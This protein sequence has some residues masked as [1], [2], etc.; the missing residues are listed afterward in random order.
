MNNQLLFVSLFSIA[1]MRCDYPTT[2]LNPDIYVLV[3]NFLNIKLVKGLFITLIAIFSL[4]VITAISTIFPNSRAITP[5]HDK[6]IVAQEIRVDNTYLAENSP[7]SNRVYSQKSNKTKSSP[8]PQVISSEL[9]AHEKLVIKASIIPPFD[10]FSETSSI[11]RNTLIIIGLLLLSM[12]ILTISLVKTIQARKQSQ[13]SEK[14]FKA[15][16]EASPAAIMIFQN[17]KLRFANSS[18]E[19]LTGF[20]REELLTMEIWQLIH[21]ES[22]RDLNKDKT[23]LEG[24]GFNFRA[25]L[26]VITKSN[27]KKWID[28]STRSIEFD[29]QASVLATAIDVTDKKNYEQQL[30]EAEERYALILLASN[31]GISDYSILSDQLYLSI[32][33]KNML[34]FSEDEFENTIVNWVSLVYADDRDY[35]QKLLEQLNKGEHSNHTTEYRMICK[36]GGYQWVSASFSV[37]FDSTNKP[38]RVL[39]THSNIT[40]RKKTEEKLKESE[41]RYKSLFY[42]NSAVMLITAPESGKIQD[43]NQAAVDYYGFEREE[44]LGMNFSD[45]NLDNQQKEPE[46]EQDTAN[47]GKKSFSH[48]RHKLADG[49]V[50]DVEIYSSKIQVKAGIMVYSIIFDITERKK[51]EIELQKAKE[52]AEEA[53][54]EKTFFISNVSHEIRTPLNAIIGLTEL[55]MEDENLSDSHLEN[56]RSIKY[57]SDH[58]L[59]VINDVL[60]FSKLEAG[61]VQLEKTEFDVHNLVKESA[62]T[63]NFKAKEKG[64]T[65]NIS[66]QPS[67]PKVLLGDPSRLRQ[68]ILNL[69][70]NAIKFTHEGHINIDVLLL[71]EYENNLQLRFSVSDTG[72]GIPETKVNSIFESFTQA[73]TNTSRKFGGTGLGLSICKKLVE[74]QN[75]QMGVKSVEG[76]GSTFWFDLT[77]EVSLKTFLPDANKGYSS[78]KNLRGFKIL[79]VE[80][81]KMNQFVMAQIMKKWLAKIDIVDNGMMAIQKL[82]QQKYNLVLMDLHMPELNGYEATKIIRNPVSNVLDHDVPI[83]ALTADV[84]LETRERVKNAGMNDFLSKPSDKNEM[85]EKIIQA[86][87][88]NKSRFIENKEQ[89]SNETVAQTEKNFN[90]DKTKYRIKK[91]LADIFD[92]DLEGTLGLIT[93]FLKDIPKTIVGVNEAFYDNDYELLNSL[94]HRIKP[95]YSY[96][97]F[98]DVSEKIDQ[99]Q[100]LTQSKSHTKELEKL[101]MELDDDSRSIVK[102]LREIKTEYIESDSVDIPPR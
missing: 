56:M 55:F 11:F 16:L 37:V 23:T 78:V 34:G 96:M 47:K 77:Y 9:L 62:Q 70:S 97:G 93:R 8:N 86:V 102:I 94:V 83:I 71:N 63:I 43:V 30:I 38:I 7:I 51:I 10:L 17:F 26:Q 49:N 98:K 3:L 2:C 91:A 45:I 54:R 36:D 42:K 87:I 31:D 25:E 88:K 24:N 19:I 21:P 81:D 1:I 65:I 15:L 82:E 100:R 61:K 20:S 41:F 4:I 46:L 13:K 73:E 76:M 44:L 50:R 14:R 39:G 53:Y 33:W 27:G 18:L 12:L 5:P 59:G 72:I 40:E 75:G 64:I 79:L 58:L 6:A 95:G 52:K 32:Q 35:V 60:D 84:S 68:I 69:L 48:S 22:L 90:D 67:I 85:F 99:I 92:D 74:L 80:D 28:F 101:C 29:N 66:I 57:S 89:Q